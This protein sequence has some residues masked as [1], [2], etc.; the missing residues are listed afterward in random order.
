[1]RTLLNIDISHLSHEYLASLKEEVAQRELNS[2]TIN[3]FNTIVEPLFTVDL[4]RLQ[5]DFG[6]EFQ[7]LSEERLELMESILHTGYFIKETLGDGYVDWLENLLGIAD[8]PLM[9]LDNVYYNAI[10]QKDEPK[11]L[12]VQPLTFEKDLLKY[13]KLRPKYT[14]P[15][16]LERA[17]KSGLD[18]WTV[19]DTT[20]YALKNPLFGLRMAKNIDE[21]YILDLLTEVLNGQLTGF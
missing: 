6:V 19:E 13:R 4:V 18:V 14:E 9:L 16:V 15:R 5:L 10:K 8:Y 17:L 11:Y 20:I 21:M 1:M 2:V 7:G 12:V 3:L